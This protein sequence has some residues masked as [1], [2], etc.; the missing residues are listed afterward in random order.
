[1][2]IAPLCTILTR[3]VGRVAVMS[4]GVVLFSG[5]FIAASFA[6]QIWHLYL[7]QGLLVG[8]GIGSLYVSPSSWKN[9]LDTYLISHPD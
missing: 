1:M 6:S 9:R 2:I 7:T 3:E 8:L 5:G 4:V